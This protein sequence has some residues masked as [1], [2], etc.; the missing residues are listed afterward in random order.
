MSGRHIADAEG[1]FR[2]CNITPDMC[3]VN[4]QVVPFDIYQELPPEKANYAK[5]VRARGEKV[6]HVN[7]I[8]KGVIGNAGKGVS[9][10][11][12]QGSGDTWIT[13]GAKSVRVEGQL[14]AR[15]LDLCE[16][17]CRTG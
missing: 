16:M 17:N 14:C 12:S 11:V 2:V 7:S 15:H 13:E 4:G 5:K 10:G 3:I 8:I 9:S 1:I 6:L